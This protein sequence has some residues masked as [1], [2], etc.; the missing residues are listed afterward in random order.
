MK[1]VLLMQLFL[2]SYSG[3]AALSQSVVTKGQESDTDVVR[4]LVSSVSRH[5]G[6]WQLMIS[7][8][9]S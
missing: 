7:V 6:L 4:Q 2:F 5:T 8:T 3:Q 9:V 1:D